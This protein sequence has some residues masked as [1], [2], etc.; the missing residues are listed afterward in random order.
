MRT[1]LLVVG[2]S[3]VAACGSDEGKTSPRHTSVGSQFPEGWSDFADTTCRVG[4]LPLKCLGRRGSVAKPVLGETYMPIPPRL[5]DSIELPTLIEES[6]AVG[7]QQCL[8]ASSGEQVCLPRIRPRLCSPIPTSG[9]DLIGLVT[10]SRVLRDTATV[11]D[12]DGDETAVLD[13]AKNRFCDL[14]EDSEDQ[15]ARRQ[16]ADDLDLDANGDVIRSW[17]EEIESGIADMSR[18]ANDLDRPLVEL[19]EGEATALNRT[20]ANYLDRPNLRV[21]ALTHCRIIRAF[22]IPIPVC[23]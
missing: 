8:A 9:S 7:Y 6:S 10:G 14:L 5:S 18:L 17:D 23:T 19:S 20:L 11:V 4:E 1:V 15:D 21:L 22:R 16:N 12:S 3:L 2:V 13:I